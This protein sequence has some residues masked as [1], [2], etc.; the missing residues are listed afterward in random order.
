MLKRL[1]CS[2]SEP[3]KAPCDLAA[4]SNMVWVF[5]GDHMATIKDRGPLRW[6]KDDPRYVCVSCEQV[7]YTPINLDVIIE[8]TKELSQ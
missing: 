1:F 3:I 6:V 7:D 5:H 4:A 8:R 2:K